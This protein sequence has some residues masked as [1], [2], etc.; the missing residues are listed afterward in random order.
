MRTQHE[1]VTFRSLS[2][3]TDNVA[4]SSLKTLPHEKQRTGIIFQL[5]KTISKF[6]KS[7]IDAFACRRL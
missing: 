5:S 6:F 1:R 7:F 2:W 4:H 3:A